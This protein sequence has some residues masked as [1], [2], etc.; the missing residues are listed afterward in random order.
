MSYY[1]LHYL[2]DLHMICMVQLLL[3]LFPFWIE[4]IPISSDLKVFALVSFSMM[5]ALPVV[6]RLIEP[7][8][9]V[10]S[11]KHSGFNDFGFRRPSINL[12]LKALFNNQR[13]KEK[14]GVSSSS[15]RK[16]ISSGKDA[17]I[18]LKQWEQS[19]YSRASST[20][21]QKLTLEDEKYLLIKLDEIISLLETGVNGAPSHEAGV[22]V[23]RV[24]WDSGYSTWLYTMMNRTKSMSAA[25]NEILIQCVRER[26]TV[27]NRLAILTSLYTEILVDY[28]GENE[29]V[30]REDENSLR[31]I[32]VH[33]ATLSTSSSTSASHGSFTGKRSVH[34]RFYQDLLCL[35]LQRYSIESTVTMTKGRV[36][37]IEILCNHICTMTSID[38]LK[39]ENHGHDKDKE[40]RD[41]LSH[42]LTGGNGGSNKASVHP[43]PFHDVHRD[44]LPI[45]MSVYQRL[46][47]SKDIVPT[48]SSTATMRSPQTAAV[49][50]PT[51][52]T[53]EKQNEKKSLTVK[54]LHR[55]VSLTIAML[56]LSIGATF[57]H[58]NHESND[59]V[60]QMKIRT[61]REIFDR[62][63]QRFTDYLL[64][65]LIIHFSHY[66]SQNSLT[67]LSSLSG[68]AN[69]LLIFTFILQEQ[70]KSTS[71]AT[72]FVDVVDRSAAVMEGRG[73][74]KLCVDVVQ[75][76]MYSIKDCL[77][78]SPTD[79]SSSASITKELSSHQRQYILKECSYCHVYIIKLFVAIISLPGNWEM[80]RSNI[81]ELIKDTISCVESHSIALS[82]E[83]KK[84]DIDRFIA[85][86]KVESAGIVPEYATGQRG[87]DGKKES[88]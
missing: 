52:S 30:S 83:S 25:V 79:G 17:W 80:E 87:N 27:M 34:A 28:G 44:L 5:S 69:I 37:V 4:S 36:S 58:N 10:H 74:G 31:R 50:S 84:A 65:V 35:L 70:G 26:I 45:L 39:S 7:P 21:K 85:Y 19:C 8:S 48:P 22:E 3:L 29:T 42:M 68:I 15:S 71:S 13:E 59:R 88:S 78:S 1:S 38:K 51:S 9:G 14:M 66:N 61:M 24:L 2:T 86:I 12:P 40:V 43:S 47:D 73:I 72:S 81:Q 16:K 54:A 63:R 76:V 62:E 75:L 55:R 6:C 20:G 57:Y 67:W 23:A 56:F 82:E 33:A 64:H 60:M 41:S 77:Y 49:S 53:K 46:R 11:E 18:F 32:L